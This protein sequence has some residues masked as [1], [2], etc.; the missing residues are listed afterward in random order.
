M[1]QQQVIA[2]EGGVSKEELLQS[3]SKQSL[4]YDANYLE[5]GVS[6]KAASAVDQAGKIN[7]PSALKHAHLVC[8]GTWTHAAYHLTSAT[9]GPPL[10][11]LPF[12][13]AALGWGPGIVALFMGAI[14]SYYA[15]YSLSQAMQHME[16]QGK[17]SFRFCD[18]SQHILGSS[19]TTYVVAPLQL[20]VC[21]MV[22]IG[23]TLLG[24]Q[25]M[26]EMFYT[27]NENGTLE[28]FEF[29][30][31]FGIL[32][33]LLSQI[34][35]MH[36]LRHFNMVSILLCFG[37]SICAF[38]GSLIAGFSKTPEATRD[39]KVLGSEMTRTFG[40]FTAICVMVTSYSNP[41][42]VEIQASLAEPIGKKMVRGLTVCYGVA[43]A[44]FFPVAVAGYWA[45]GNKANGVV[46]LN[47][48]EPKQFC[49]VPR[50]LYFSANAC[51]CVQ[52]VVYTVLHLHPTFERLEVIAVDAEQGKFSKRN[53]TARLL[54]R[55]FFV[56]MS[57]LLAA[58][59]PFF[60][61][62]SAFMGAVG[63]TPICLFLP[64]LFYNIIF[65]PSVK[66]LT[67]WIN[68]LIM[69]CACVI[70]LLGGISSMRNIISQA[71]T[72]RLFADV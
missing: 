15:C 26:K 4:V 27:Y 55:S 19:W 25:T 13:M 11:S 67:F 39:Y 71:T 20:S 54:T 29:I 49:L 6:F 18:L 21:F 58:M 12:A 5:M 1:V 48:F 52:L 42:V 8:K 23:G 72:Y 68:Y 44:T 63:F 43:I 64:I 60:V 34:P 37:Y 59:L 9:A 41:L 69:S 24:G 62:F 17:R 38:I 61:E 14:V 22:V 45:F 32:V 2:V 66:T 3:A 70:M 51:A 53:F 30:V 31:V 50:W 47:L 46:L 65:K 56:V 35:S 16:L 57:T 10:L 36:S 28:L 7:D 33:L 40:I